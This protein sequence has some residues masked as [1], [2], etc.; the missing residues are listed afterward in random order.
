LLTWLQR[1]VSLTFSALKRYSFEP[2]E[3]VSYHG[4]VC[5][6]SKMPVLPAQRYLRFRGPKRSPLSYRAG[7]ERGSFCEPASAIRHHRPVCTNLPTSLTSGVAGGPGPPETVLRGLDSI[8]DGGARVDPVERPGPRPWPR[9]T[10]RDLITPASPELASCD[11][12]LRAGVSS[13]RISL[14]WV[15][16]VGQRRLERTR[17][18][19][20]L[21]E[22]FQSRQPA[23]VGVAAVAD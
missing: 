14:G 17:R 20:D 10:G 5:L 18:V 12:M 22:S 9:V 1:D 15:A 19:T 6:I 2:R 11:S 13:R 7:R 16:P 8:C 23:G 3:T 21:H 4:I